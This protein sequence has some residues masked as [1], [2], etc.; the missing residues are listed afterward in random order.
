MV[1]R[2]N[3]RPVTTARDVREILSLVQ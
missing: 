2:H 1:T 3:L